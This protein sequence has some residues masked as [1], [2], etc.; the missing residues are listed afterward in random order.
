MAATT[1]SHLVPSSLARRWIWQVVVA[2]FIFAPCA[3]LHYGHTVDSASIAAI[4]TI[5]TIAAPCVG[6]AASAGHLFAMLLAMDATIASS[7]CLV[8]KG[9]PPSGSP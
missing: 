3:A 8:S 7:S 4:A 9:P 1:V 2:I 5:A 6:V